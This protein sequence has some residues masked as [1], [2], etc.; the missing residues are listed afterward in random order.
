MPQDESHVS[1]IQTVEVKLV[2]TSKH[3]LF[4][5]EAKKSVMFCQG[6]DN[7]VAKRNNKITSNDEIL[8]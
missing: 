6:D 8:N 2:H 5:N 4:K 3:T 1:R 7:V